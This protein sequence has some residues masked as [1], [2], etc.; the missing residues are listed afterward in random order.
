MRKWLLV[1]IALLLA[2]T[3]LYAGAVYLAEPAPRHAFFR[4]SFDVVAHR[5][6]AALR[7]ENTLAAFEHA[8]SLGADVIEMDLRVT[9]DGA[10]VLMHDATVE[11]TT[12]G[13][14]RVDALT[15]AQLRE[16]RVPALAEVFE[17]LPAMR[18]NLEMKQFDAA[19]AEGLC[20]LV[21]QHGMSPRVLVASAGDE[22][23]QAFRRACPEVATALTAS[24]AR[25]FAA[26]RDVYPLPAAALEI[27]DAVSYLVPAAL[28]RGLK[29]YVW[30]V[31][32]PARMRELMQAGVSGII[33]DRPDLLLR[34]REERAE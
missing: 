32:D 12:G 8:A 9:R 22:P 20:A 7:P 31:N 1:A 15:L 21:R 30:T 26:L 11:R 14:G 2:G 16:L 23:M 29:V 19:Q 17:R 34:L 5:G 18:M 3:A 6:G 10:I 27:P 28:A 33:T 24:E 13:K 25:W 4:D